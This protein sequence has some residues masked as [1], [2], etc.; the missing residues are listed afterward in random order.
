VAAGFNVVDGRVV[1][2]DLAA[3]YGVP[4]T[5]LMDIL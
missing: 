2:R 4:F 3:L 5:D 1:Y